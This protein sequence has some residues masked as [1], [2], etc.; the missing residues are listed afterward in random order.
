MDE[1]YHLHCSVAVDNKSLTWNRKASSFY[2]HGFATL[3]SNDK[4]NNLHSVHNI[5]TTELE[6]VK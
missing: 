6:Y 5:C 4:G 1:M 2:A 3:K